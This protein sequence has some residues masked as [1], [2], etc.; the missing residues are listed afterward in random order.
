[1]S[2]FQTKYERDVEQHHK[3]LLGFFKKVMRLNEKEATELDEL[4][5]DFAKAVGE[6][7]ASEAL[8]REFNRGDYRY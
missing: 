5:F 1:V 3:S 2:T 4:L 6:H 8:D 7:Y